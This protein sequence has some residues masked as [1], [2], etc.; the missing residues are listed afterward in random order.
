MTTC[1][2][3]SQQELNISNCIVQLPKIEK[4]Y[5]HHI[6]SHCSGRDHVPSDKPKLKSRMCLFII[7]Q[8]DGTPFDATS[9]TKED[10]VEM[11]I[12]MGYTHP[13]GVLHY[14]VME[15]IAL[16]CSTEEMQHATC[17]AI[18]A[19]ELQEGAIS[20]RDVAY[21]IAVGGDSSKLQS[22]PS[23]EEGEPH[24]SHDNPHQVGKCVISK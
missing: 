16:F 22:P 17:R 7:T 8:K 15:L 14:S 5:V 3:L 2:I 18:K 19:T 4:T 24:S 11:C 12:K 23:E 1:W 9:V 6:L 21:I 10:I 20:L 13:L